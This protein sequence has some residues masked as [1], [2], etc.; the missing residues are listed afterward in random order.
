MFSQFETDTIKVLRSN[1]EIIDNIKAGVQAKIIFISNAKIPIQSGDV[2]TRELPS[3]IEERFIVIDPGYS[4]GMGAIKP[5]YQVKYEREDMQKEKVAP[6]TIIYNVS[7]ENSRVNVN[8]HD[9]S[10]N[11]V[12]NAPKELFETI[13]EVL[14][15]EIKSTEEKDNLIDLANQL[16]NAQGTTSFIDKYKNFMSSASDHMGVLS[17]LL[18]ALAALLV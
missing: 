18:P 7:G 3:G 16:E 9:H 8:S 17:P 11:Q 6:S 13:R 2:I 10:I 12:N 1:G 4:A 5:H 15:K 14:S